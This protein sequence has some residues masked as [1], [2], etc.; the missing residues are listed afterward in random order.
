VVEFLRLLM[1]TIIS[2]TN[3]KISSIQINI[4]L[5]SF[6]CLIALAIT[7]STILKRY[8]DNALLFLFPSL[9]E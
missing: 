1:Y 7:S 6:V 8:G 4:L 2:S 3:S 9:M 5:I